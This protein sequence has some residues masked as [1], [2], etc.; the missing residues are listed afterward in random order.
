MRLRNENP[1]WIAAHNKSDYK[2]IVKKFREGKKTP[3]T[4]V[5]FNCHVVDLVFTVN[6]LIQN[7]QR[8]TIIKPTLYDNYIIM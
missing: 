5:S 6:P 1:I 8:D 4:T 3:K 2:D 7:L